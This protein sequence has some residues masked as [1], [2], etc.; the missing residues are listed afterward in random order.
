MTRTLEGISDGKI[1]DIEDKVKADACGCEDCSACCH[2][3]GELV[4]L[5]PFDAYEMRHH[6]KLSFDE[7]LEDKL[8]LREKNKVLLPHLR[9][10]GDME[11]CSF[12][13]A[14]GR[15]TIHAYRP[16]ICRLFPLGRIYEGDDFKYFLQI[17]SCLKPNLKEVIVSQWIGIDNYPDNKAF[18]LAW[19]ALLK[20]LTF[21][22]KFT[23]DEEELATIRQYLLDTFYRMTLKE[24]EDFYTAF[25]RC[26]PEAKKWLG[27]I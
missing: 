1:Y 14:E 10:Q 18:I 13:N 6:L 26:L 20:T 7:L 24:G 11:R 25:W 2:S 19:H 9:M 4:M 3:V 15:C 21:R 12:L 27:I 5:T 16:N 23:R 17:N 8:E 22:L